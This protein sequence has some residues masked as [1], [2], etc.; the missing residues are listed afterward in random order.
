MA[1]TGRAAAAAAAGALVVLVLHTVAALVTV[2]AVIGVAI[3]ADVA[4]AAPVRALRLT[5]SGDTRI[6]LGA[7]G[8]VT[9]AVAS[10]SRRALHGT[11]RDAWQPSAGAEPGRAELSVTGGGETSV[12]TTLTPR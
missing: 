7:S 8:T 10:A 4:L 2:D 6:R 12:T 5:R 3:V 11:V 9:L 1:L